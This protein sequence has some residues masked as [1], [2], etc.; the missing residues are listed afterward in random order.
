[1]GAE[2]DFPL[3]F[4]ICSEANAESPAPHSCPVLRVSVQ[5]TAQSELNSSYKPL[6]PSFSLKKVTGLY[7]QPIVW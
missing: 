6:L 4:F 2:K 7:P 1:M 5:V 3:R